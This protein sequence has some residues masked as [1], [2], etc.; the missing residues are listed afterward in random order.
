[1][2]PSQFA[3][4]V[5]YPNPFNPETTLAFELKTSEIVSLVIYDLIGQEIARLVDGFKSPGLHRITWNAESL[6]S[7]IYFARMTTGAFTQ[8][9][10]LLLIK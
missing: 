2:N 6:P 10:K 3:L 9:Q 1:M 8:T 5:N 4:H 7:G